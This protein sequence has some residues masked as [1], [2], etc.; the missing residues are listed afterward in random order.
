MKKPRL[1]RLLAQLRYP[2]LKGLFDIETHLTDR[3]KVA[4]FQL[5]KLVT[6]KSAHSVSIVEIG[7]YLGASSN[8]L[9][10][11]IQNVQMG[12]VISVDTWTNN[13]MSEG[14]RDTMA[15]YVLNTRRLASLIKP[16]RG[17]STD[18]AVVSEVSRHTTGRIDLLFIDGD[19]AYES[20]LADWKT[21][22]PLLDKRAIV[23]MHDIGWAEGVRRVVSEEIRPLVSR[24]YRLP[25]LW[26]GQMAP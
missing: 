15:D 1:Y 14:A 19:H 10:A 26:W 4:L 7:A 23:A 9:A 5:S 13:A 3:E 11:G 22:S 17:L 20:V 6:A 2:R 18:P 24:E 8:F 21:Y 12:Q 16:V 25:N